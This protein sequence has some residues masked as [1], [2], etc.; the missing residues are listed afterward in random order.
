M[1][2]VESDMKYDFTSIIDR[3]GKDAAALDGIG[4][5][6]WGF[7]PEPAKPGFDEIPMWVADMN[8]ATCPSIT[9]E[10]EERI[11]HPLYGYFL[12][13]DDYYQ[14]IINWQTCRHGYKGLTK[15]MIGYE[16]GVHG[17]IVSAL[18]ALSEPGD[19]V[20]LHSPTYVGFIG[21]LKD[22]GRRMVLSPLE[23]DADGIW[24]MNFEDM[25]RKIQKYH[26]HIAIF[27]SPH[28]PTGRVWERWELEKAMDIFRKHDVIVISDEIWSDI[29]FDGHKHIPTCMISDDAASRTIDIYAPSKTFNLAGLI[30]SYHIISN[31]VLRE[32]VKNHGDRTHYNEMNVLS[33]HALIGAYAE[34]GC[35]WTD[36]LCEVLEENCRYSVDFI[37]NRLDGCEVSM[38]QGTYM[39]FM[40]CTGYLKKHHMSLDELLKCG[41]DV[42]VAWED[43]RKFACDN[44]IRLNVALPMSRLQ[45]AF[46]RMEQ[47]IFI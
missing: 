4:K 45:E 46:R 6:L 11:Q 5:N 26:I 10:L 27:C 35:E 1:N 34:E 42:G 2:G 39:L 16:N 3:T 33:M 43:G 47:Y 19:A 20:L 38:P 7:A 41:W 40:D 32:K 31:P 25:E 15:D 37:N 17:C 12:P 29:V 30:G 22:T 8:F 28:N 14:S 36:E 18:S 24:R 9:K 23:K 13:T 21:D 44:S